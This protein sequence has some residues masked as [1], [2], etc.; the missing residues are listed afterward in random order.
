[1]HRHLLAISTVLFAVVL[2]FG[3]FNRDESTTI[4]RPNNPHWFFSPY[5]WRP[6]MSA[7]TNTPGA[8][9]KVRFSGTSCSL[10]VD[11]SSLSGQS[12]GDYPAIAYSVDGGVWTRYQLTSSDEILSL[13][14]GLADTN[15]DL[16]VVLVGAYYTVDRWTTPVMALTVTG[17]MLDGGKSLSSPTTYSGRCIVYGD[18]N[19]EGYEALTH[20]VSVANQDAGQAYPL[21]IGRAFECEVGVVAFA[22]QG[23]TATGG[24]NV[25]DL[26]DAWDFYYS[27]QSRLDTGLF[28]PEPDYIF[29]MMGQNDSSG[30]QTAVENLIAAWRT[31]APSAAI[32]LCSPSNLNQASAIEAGVTAAADDNTY[33]VT[34]GQDFLGS[35][36]SG[37]SKQWTNANHLSVRGHA[38]YAA[39]LIR[40]IEQEL[41]P[42]VAEVAAA[43]WSYAERT[44]TP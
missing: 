36:S 43:V 26:E 25:P 2:S 5:N 27:G 31:A 28:S 42:T 41:Q 13:A 10:V 37:T 44:L 7:I 23:Y 21:L 14:S 34:T 35:W 17:L 4:I 16:I 19:G 30:V 15:H 22:A 8:Y 11:V 20:G 38:R 3:N 6:G 12:A 9:F 33:W 40:A 24:G 39:A 32:V 29:C 18:S 1:M